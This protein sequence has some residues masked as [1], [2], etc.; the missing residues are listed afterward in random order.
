MQI[1]RL[2]DVNK[3]GWLIILSFIPVANIYPLIL[4]CMKGSDSKKTQWNKK[5]SVNLI[6]MAIFIVCIIITSNLMS[7]L[8]NDNSS[9]DESSL[10]SVEQGKE[11]PNCFI[12]NLARFTLYTTEGDINNE[13]AVFHYDC[14]RKLDVLLFFNQSRMDARLV[15]ENK[16]KTVLNLDF[17]NIGLDMSEPEGH[18]PYTDNEYLIGQY[19]FDGD[20]VDELLIAVKSNHDEAGGDLGGICLNIWRLD[21]M[22]QW[23]LPASDIL[24]EPAC[25]LILNKI[26]IPRN[27]RDFY[28]EWTFQNG[29]FEYTGNY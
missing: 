19:D 8:N 18:F 2:H 26:K 28:Y 14:G 24:G 29:T 15:D 1:R 17:E 12:E 25:E 11:K 21:D 20:K 4:F 6:F 10:E 7:G 27:L 3:S 5:D 23:I 9:N 13:G 22:Q 16:R